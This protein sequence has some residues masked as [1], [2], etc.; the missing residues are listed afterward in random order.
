MSVLD[1]PTLLTDFGYSSED[2][3]LDNYLTD[4]IAFAEAVMCRHGLIFY[5]PGNPPTATTKK[6]STSDPHVWVGY[7][8]LISSVVKKTKFTPES[9]TLT[10]GK[11]YES[12]M[13]APGVPDVSLITSLDLYEPLKSNQYLEVTGVFAFGDESKFPADLKIAL[14]STLQQFAEYFISKKKK[15]ANGG[16]T[17]SQI[18]VGKIDIKNGTAKDDITSMYN[19]IDPGDLQSIFSVNHKFNQVLM[20]Y[21]PI[22]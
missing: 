10:D 15:A 6:F 9:E 11:D 19:G 3:Q 2:T 7:A 14:K 18:K 13:Y 5:A 12:N 16:Q 20:E 17:A 22:V 4:A 1:A 8:E 21:V